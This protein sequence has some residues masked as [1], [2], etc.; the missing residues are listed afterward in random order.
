MARYGV[1]VKSQNQASS[2]FSLPVS[3]KQTIHAKVEWTPVALASDGGEGFKVTARVLSAEGYPRSMGDAIISQGFSTALWVWKRP[4]GEFE[5]LEPSA[6]PLGASNTLKLLALPFQFQSK[7][8][9]THKTE[10]DALGET[11]VHY[12]SV[13]HG[14]LARARSGYAHLYQSSVKIQILKNNATIQFRPSDQR[15]LS[16]TE[17]SSLMAPLPSG[18][19]LSTQNF[20]ELSLADE[21]PLEPT[22]AVE[23]KRTDLSTLI[24]REGLRKT[25]H[26]IIFIPGS[27]QPNAKPISEILA[28]LKP[29]AKGEMELLHELSL[30]LAKDPSK[31]GLVL[32][33]VKSSIT[34]EEFSVRL[35]SAL[36]STR[37]PQAQAAMREA[38]DFYRAQKKDRLAIRAVRS[39]QLSGYGDRESADYLWEMS[40]DSRL[41]AT[42]KQAAL[43]SSGSVAA[44]S[45]DFSLSQELSESWQKRFE[46]SR[47]D[48]ER[49]E[50]LSAMG[51]LADPSISPFVIQIAERSHSP[52]IK[53]Q[54][55][56]ALRLIRTEES[57]RYLLGVSTTNSVAGLRAAALQALGAK[58]L[59]EQACQVLSKRYLTLLVE[60][61]VPGVRERMQI[62]GSLARPEHRQYESL[63]RFLTQTL[64]KHP[65][66]TAQEHRAREQYVAVLGDLPG[67]E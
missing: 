63:K 46:G 49:A 31:I 19:N 20:T 27:S 23:C 25:S 9:K 35:L 62:L 43:L 11:F 18:A 65:Q 59:S 45:G 4:T 21:V 6:S 40:Q 52:R 3:G 24:A 34:N 32:A 16:L 17:S 56:D 38:L 2:G 41:P 37:T 33:K 1:T 30:Q 5:L 26:E 15:L 42:V 61:G 28:Q 57:E 39:M 53:E 14:T 47:T 29:G 67:K 58:P 54:A 44:K 7:P 60:T 13:S 55:I 50:W 36:S 8:D 64:A 48:F 66:L 12:R 51:N 10:W 22:K